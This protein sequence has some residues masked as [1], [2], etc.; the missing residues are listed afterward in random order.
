LGRR[1]QY[2]DL[3]TGSTGFIGNVLI[4]ELLKKGRDVKAFMRPTSDTSILEDLDIEKHTGNILDSPS[5]DRAFKGVD[6]VYHLAARITLLPWEDSLI[7]ECNLE[8]TRNVLKACLKNGVQKLIYTS[9]IHALKEP[10]EGTVIDE[11]MPYD[12]AN[13]RGE[14]DRSKALS[15]MEILEAGKNGLHTVVVCPT[16]TLGPF[17]WKVSS[18][19]S[20]FIDYYNRKMNIGIGGAYDF[21]D[22]RDVAA[23]HILAAGKAPPGENYILSGERVTMRQMFAILE[24]VTGVPA[25]SVYVPMGLARTFSRI[26]P[27][28]YRLSKRPP[29]FTSYSLSTLRSNSFISHEKASRELGYRARTVKQSVKDTF[30]WLKDSGLVK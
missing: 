12:P 2:M 24:E 7:K 22:V 15:S 21:V 10:P 20:M 23:G 30:S 29:V 5:L 25:P 26:T 27:L 4:R 9:T 14:Y 19:T 8:G 6:T 28:Y 17:D 16:G 18:I 11:K 3:V 1:L 13:Q